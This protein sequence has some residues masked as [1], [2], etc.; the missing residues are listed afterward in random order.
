MPR[1]AANGIE[2]E[3]EPF[4]DPHDP[5]LLLI[6]G[7]GGQMIAWDDDLCRLLAERGF[8]VVRYDN[9]DTGLSTKMDGFEP[10]D[11]LDVF[12]GAAVP[13]TLDDMADDAAGLL[14][15]LGL[16]AAHVVGLSMGGMIAQ[17]VAIRHAQRVLSLVSISSAAGGDSLVPPTDEALEVLAAPP[18][19]TRGEHVEQTVRGS[20]VL[21]SPGFAFDAERAATAAAAA[22]DRCFYPPGVAR[23]TA[24]IVA[25][26]SR[27]PALRTLRVPTLVV[28]GDADTLVPVGNAFVT[29]EAVPDARLLVIPGMAHELPPEMWEQ[30]AT[31]IVA[32]AERAAGALRNP[33]ASS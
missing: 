6:M 16:Q 22:Y 7:L 13:Y 23:Q 3:Y 20:R 21:A 12:A 31:A 11:L 19:A 27:V 9:R 33:S 17:L 4:G 18:A 2:I 15:A 29:A 1:I 25:A 8:R 24:A 32:N 26:P 5:P 10:P 28:H 14:D 30:I